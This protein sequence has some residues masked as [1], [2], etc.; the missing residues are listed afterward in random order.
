MV[1]QISAL[2]S[3]TAP[4][5]HDSVRDD[6]PDTA[7]LSFNELW[8][9]KE[10]GLSFGDLL[11]IV[12]PLHHIP[13]VS[14]IYRMVTGDE[15]GMG[16]RLAGGALFG[17]PIGFAAAGIVAGVEEASGASVEEHVASLFGF[18]EK[19]S[20]DTTPLP[21][22]LASLSAVRVAPAAGSPA[23]TATGP[24]QASSPIAAFPASSAVAPA[25]QPASAVP[26]QASN[27]AANAGLAERIAQAQRAQAGL[28]AASLNASHQCRWRN[29]GALRRRGRGGSGNRGQFLCPGADAVPQPPLHAPA[30]RAV[31]PGYPDHGTRAAA[32]SSERAASGRAAA[33]TKP[34]IRPPAFGRIC[35]LLFPLHSFTRF[36]V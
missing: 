17:G 10:K 1:D 15:I 12:N 13:V 30:Q 25:S 14:T 16:A 27:D 4:I 35:A 2:H 9:D 8:Q 21:P 26:R 24:V 3:P 5:V 31:K 28:L 11:D 33:D 6:L 32:L 29:R 20:V 7:E 34:L 19:P 18:D 36:G 23:A 22:Q